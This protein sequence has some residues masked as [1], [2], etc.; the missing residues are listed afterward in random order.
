MEPILFNVKK[1][2]FLTFKKICLIEFFE[3]IELKRYNLVFIFG[4]FHACDV[5]PFPDNQLI[6]RQISNQLGRGHKTIESHLKLI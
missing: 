4:H 2:Y 5:I 6:S 3:K 1:L